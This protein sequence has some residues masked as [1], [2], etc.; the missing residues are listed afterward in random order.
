MAGELEL[1]TNETIRVGGGM[2]VMLHNQL[3]LVSLPQKKA[4]MWLEDVYGTT[5][6]R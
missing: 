3:L 4:G 5:R 1:Q 6:P 2:P